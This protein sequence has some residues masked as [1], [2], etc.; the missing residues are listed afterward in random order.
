MTNIGNAKVKG[1]TVSLVKRRSSN[2]LWAATLDYTFQIG[3]GSYTDPLALAVDTRTGRVT[4]QKLVPLS[5]DRTHTLNG[6]LTLT[7][8]SSWVLS[9]IGSIYNGT[10]YTP[11]LPSSIKPVEF[12]VNS[13]RKPW[14]KNVDLKFEKFFKIAKTRFSVFVDVRNVFDIKNELFVWNNTVVCVE[15]YRPGINQFERID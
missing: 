9:I 1:F 5:Y 3:M 15:Q 7:K 2:G 6:T 8:P 12:E 14:V 4:P 13:A 11:S 10:P